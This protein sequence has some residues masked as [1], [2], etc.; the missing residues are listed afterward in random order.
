M[1]RTPF[2]TAA[3][4]AAIFYASPSLA[5]EPEHGSP[6]PSTSTEPAQLQPRSQSNVQQA[7]PAA[8]EPVGTAST[9]AGSYARPGGEWAVVREVER[10]PNHALLGTG[11]GLF[12]M[13]YVPT[14]FAAAMSDRDEDR[15]LF[16]PI[17]GP[18]M[19]IDQRRCSRM[20]PCGPEEE[21]ARAMTVTSGIVQGVST[22]LVIGSL[23]IPETTRVL[24]LEGTAKKR[25]VG[26]IPVSYT[27]GAGIG[28]VGRF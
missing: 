3:F 8:R 21:F 13:S 24:Q 20:S 25:S 19:A 2:A 10:Y 9:T 15:R 14:A 12:I 27:G 17:A 16:I 18:W 22:L 28:A 7:Q 26:V 5:D 23:V 11:A 6:P 4:V 1:L